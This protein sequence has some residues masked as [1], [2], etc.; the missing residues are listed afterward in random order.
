MLETLI[1]YDICRTFTLETTNFL[2]LVDFILGRKTLK[3]F[4]NFNSIK[5]LYRY[6][7]I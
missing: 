7:C 2:F 5:I 4:G 3:S 6:F 1:F